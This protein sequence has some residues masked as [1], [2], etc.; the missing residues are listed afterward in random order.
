MFTNDIYLIYKFKKVLALNN[1][2][3]LICQ[4]TKPNLTSNCLE[5]SNVKKYS[6][7]INPFVGF[8]H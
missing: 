7:V 5:K 1:L 2:K 4:K 3:G 6:D 8:N